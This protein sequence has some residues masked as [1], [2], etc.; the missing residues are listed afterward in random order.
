[1]S[2]IHL[3]PVLELYSCSNLVFP[4]NCCQA[5]FPGKIGLYGFHL[6]RFTV[7]L[8]LLLCESGYSF[9]FVQPHPRLHAGR[10]NSQLLRGVPNAD[11]SGFNLAHC[12]IFR[13]PVYLL[14][15]IITPPTFDSVVFHCLS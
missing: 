11:L 9:R 1:M 14:S 7:H 12:L 13:A 5:P 15:H 3:N 4:A 10:M 6:Y 2:I 8:I